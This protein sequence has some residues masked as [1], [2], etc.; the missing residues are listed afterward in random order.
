MYSNLFN[1]RRSKGKAFPLF[2]SDDYIPFPTFQEIVFAIN[3]G[4][5]SSRIEIEGFTL[6]QKNTSRWIE[7]PAKLIKK[8]EYEP[9]LIVRKNIVEQHIKKL[10]IEELDTFLAECQQLF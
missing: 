3:R 5:Q 9:I 10:L 8:G 7:F 6:H 1:S 2:F 4:R